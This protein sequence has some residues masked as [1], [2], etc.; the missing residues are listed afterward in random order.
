MNIF[1]ERVVDDEGEAKIEGGLTLR[2]YFAAHALTGIVTRDD[3]ESVYSAAQKAY[4]LADI[5]LET[6]DQ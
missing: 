4:R 5:M 1:P 2:D 6:R 3:I